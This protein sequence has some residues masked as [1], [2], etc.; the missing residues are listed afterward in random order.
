M[1]AK[2]LSPGPALSAKASAT[3]TLPG[4]VGANWT[5]TVQELPGLSVSGTVHESV[6]LNPGCDESPNETPLRASGPLPV[7]VRV[8][9]WVALCPSVTLGKSKLELDGEKVANG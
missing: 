2:V 6:K 5:V 9:V 7:L 3:L 1:L 8:I 4:V